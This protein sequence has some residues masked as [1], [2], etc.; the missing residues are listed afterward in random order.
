MSIK[1]AAPNKDGL[2]SSILIPVTTENGEYIESLSNS[3]G[4]TFSDIF[5]KMI[6]E[7]KKRGF[8]DD[9]GASCGRNSDAKE[10]KEST[11]KKDEKTSSN[12]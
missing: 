9:K 1:K 7:H 8:T 4:L 6:I 2:D 5:N 10:A 12:K 3:I 11:S